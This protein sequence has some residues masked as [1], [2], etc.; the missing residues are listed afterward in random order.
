[1][2]VIGNA[3]ENEIN[4]DIPHT[5]RILA[6]EGHLDQELVQHSSQ[7]D[8]SST[9]PPSSPAH[10]VKSLFS[11]A[12]SEDDESELSS[13]PSSP[14]ELLPSPITTIRKPTFSFLKRKR[15]TNGSPS[16][17]LP[18]SETTPNVRKAPPPR[19]ALTQMQIDLGGDTRKTCRACGMEYIPS[20]KEDSAMHKEFCGMNAGGVEL[21]KPFLKDETLKRLVPQGASR[22]EREEVVIVDQRSSLAAKTKVRKVLQLVNAELSAAE[23]YD[24]TLW[25]PQ[26]SGASEKQTTGKR[27]GGQQH[28]EKGTDRFKA[29]MYLV[30]DRCVSFCLA[31]KISNAFPVVNQN[32]SASNEDRVV[33]AS[34]SSSISV[35]TTANIALLGVSRIWTSKSHRKRGLA[36]E[37]LECARNN[38]FYGVQVP[39]NLV[40]F[41]QP[42]ES[43]GRLA[44]RWFGAKTD[45]HIYRG[46]D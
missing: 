13:P 39:K 6:A 31:E 36:L 18:L 40:A 7:P 26:K 25:E 46:F 23:I 44:Q 34:K 5:N 29:F 28:H 8:A 3:V 4:A 15:S 30:G 37:L 1:M 2:D 41:S 24:E 38:F 27:K 16:I 45:W 19:A 12:G 21:G 42:T 17:Q 14:P 10:K 32:E 35:S 9:T 43:G 11:S 20:V 33:V 22:Q